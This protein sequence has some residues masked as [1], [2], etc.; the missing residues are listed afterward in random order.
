MSC[1]VYNDHLWLVGGVGL[2]NSSELIVIDLARKF[3]YGLNLEV[4]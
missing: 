3:W 2:Q 4:S 1:C